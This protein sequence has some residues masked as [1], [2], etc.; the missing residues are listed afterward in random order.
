MKCAVLEVAEAELKIG[1]LRFEL[2]S[3]L[4]QVPCKGKRYLLSFFAAGCRH[5]T[6]GTV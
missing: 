5:Q 4:P 2:F 3:D 6:S 1:L